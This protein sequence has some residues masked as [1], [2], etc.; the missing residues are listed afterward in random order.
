MAVT[1]VSSSVPTVTAGAITMPSHNAGDLIVMYVHAS[2]VS[3]LPTVPTAGGTVP[4]WNVLKS[5]AGT[6]YSNARLVWAWGTGSTTSGTWTN[7]DLFTV[8]VLRGANTTVPIGGNAISTVAAAST[9]TAP[10]I[11]L[12][13]SDGSSQLLHF[14]GFGDAVNTIGTISA[15][16]TNYTQR[17]GTVLTTKL[18]GVLNTKD[19][20]TTD[21]SVGQSISGAAWNSSASVEILSPG[22]VVDGSHQIVTNGAVSS[23]SGTYTASAGTDVFIAFSTANV[24]S[25]TSITY[26]SAAMTLVSTVPH[27]NTGQGFLSLYRAAGAGTGSSAAFSVTLSALQHGVFDIFSYGGVASLGTVTTAYGSSVTPSTGAITAN[28]G[29]RILAIVA[30]GSAGTS[31]ILSPVGGTNRAIS[32]SSV[33]YA[34]IAVSDSSSSPTTFSA[35]FGG[36]HNWSAIA[37]PLI[38]AASGVSVPTNQ[39]FTMF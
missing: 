7:A 38:P 22:P 17:V 9:S 12:A 21:G 11:T 25:I 14:H 5:T 10:A 4:T 18:A 39:F 29:E 37:V 28:A 32:T 3:T 8:A 31:T 16:P 26:N 23:Y 33:A 15:T 1:L 2:P 24:T 36:A 19:V 13:N 34:Q 30:G 6:N 20:T 35:T 27:N